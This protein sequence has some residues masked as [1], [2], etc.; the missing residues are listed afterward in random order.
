MALLATIRRNRNECAE[1]HPWVNPWNWVW[2][3]TDRW[4]MANA[5]WDELDEREPDLELI[6]QAMDLNEGGNYSEALSIWTS[7]SKQGSVRSMIELGEHHEY[8]YDVPLDLGLAETWYRKALV[9]GSQYAMLKC[10]HIAASR[11][12]FSEC[13]AI[14]QPG[15]DIG[16]ASAAFWQAWYRYNRCDSKETFRTIF[17]L[18]KIAAKCG[19]PGGRVYLTNFMVRGK[20]GI[21]R[22]PIGFFR[23]VCLAIIETPRHR[24]AE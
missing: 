22:I 24:P 6:C 23:A 12:D 3:D 20:F 16:W 7:L 11:Q 2:A 15:V 19:H 4:D 10:A 1:S 9:G 14:L 13:D 21:F 8:G 18:L 17:P 5:N